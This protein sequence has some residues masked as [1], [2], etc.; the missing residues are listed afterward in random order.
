MSLKKETLKATC[1]TGCDVNANWFTLREINLYETKQEIRAG[2]LCVTSCLLEWFETELTTSYVSEQPTHLANQ[3]ETAHNSN[4]FNYIHYVAY[5]RQCSYG[6]YH[7]WPPHCMDMPCWRYTSTVWPLRTPH[8]G[9]HWRGF[10]V[11]PIL[12][13]WSR[14]LLEKLTSCRS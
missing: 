2:T 13:P 4:K 1:S 12:T 9:A 5:K 3:T 8:L 7:A 6:N 10:R 14:V 11:R